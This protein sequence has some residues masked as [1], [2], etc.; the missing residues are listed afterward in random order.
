MSSS[1]I[2]RIAQISYIVIQK[3]TINDKFSRAYLPRALAVNSILAAVHI[4]EIM[5][6]DVS[7]CHNG[8][9]VF[10]IA[11]MTAYI[12]SNVLLNKYCFTKNDKISFSKLVKRRK[13]Q[14]LR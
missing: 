2:V 12:C 5:L 8:H 10:N 14:T 3:I 9:K 1:D 4:D 6:S 7:N 13:L 11:K